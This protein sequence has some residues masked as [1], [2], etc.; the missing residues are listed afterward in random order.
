METIMTMMMMM[1]MMM[2]K[3]MITKGTAVMMTM[4]MVMPIKE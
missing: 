3:M 1:I 2:K 4:R